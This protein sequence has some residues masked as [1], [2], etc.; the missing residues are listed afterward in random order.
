MSEPKKGVTY[1]LPVALL[2]VANPGMFQ[3]NPT[4]AAGDFKLSKDGGTLT[5]CTNL[6]VVTPAGSPILWLVL[7][8]AEMTADLVSIV[9]S[10]QAGDEWGPIHLALHT[11]IRTV[12]DVPTALQNADTLLTRDWTLVSGGPPTYSVWNALRFLRNVWSL[13]AGTPPVL[14]VKAEDGTTD[15]WT[16]NVTTNGAALPVTGVS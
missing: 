15:A 12:D 6:P 7:T 5:N 4:I 2:S 14:H 11:T 3:S 1:T 8:A 13:V 10:D 9:G 16:R